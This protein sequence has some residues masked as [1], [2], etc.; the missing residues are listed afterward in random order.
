MFLFYFFTFFLPFFGEVY[1][2]PSSILSSIY[3]PPRGHFYPSPF[4]RVCIVSFAF[5]CF[6]GTCF[7][8]CPSMPSSSSLLVF[9]LSW[10]CSLPLYLNL[11]LLLP[12]LLS[13]SSL[14]RHFHSSCF[15]SIDVLSPVHF[16]C[17]HLVHSVL[18]SL[19]AFHK[20]RP[21]R[22]ISRSLPPMSFVMPTC[23]HPFSTLALVSPLFPTSLPPSSFT[24]ELPTQIGPTKTPLSS[25]TP[26]S[27]SHLSTASSTTTTK[28]AD[29]LSKKQRQNAAKREREKAAKAQAESERLAMLARHKKD[30]ERE[31]ER[32]AGGGGKKESGGMKAV[33]DER[34]KLVWE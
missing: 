13:L 1:P 7:S 6:T 26:S 16:L 22:I 19:T 12:G 2:Y 30:K 27:S 29:Q 24:N 33:V 10:V 15:R 20:Y 17:L 21:F 9:L 4:L 31:Q 28:T 18:V 11:A 5:R 3:E 32:G 34:G 8:S 25:S 14:L 23:F